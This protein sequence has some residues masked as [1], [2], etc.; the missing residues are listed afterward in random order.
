MKKHLIAIAVICALTLSACSNSAPETETDSTASLPQTTS[1]AP[2]TTTAETEAETENAE[3]PGDTELSENTED[4]EGADGIESDNIVPKEDYPDYLYG[5]GQDKVSADEIIRAE[6]YGICEKW[7][8]ATCEGFAYL[9]EPTGISF[10]NMENPDLLDSTNFTFTGAPKSTAEYKRYSVGDTICGLTLKEAL[11][12]FSHDMGINKTNPEAYFRGGYAGFEGSV[13]LSGYAVVLVDNE[14]GLGGEGDV[15]FMPDNES[16]ILPVMNYNCFSEERGVYSDIAERC[17]SAGGLVY[18]G[19]YG[20]IVLG[21]V[22]DDEKG[23]FT[24]IEKNVPVKVRV[25]G[26]DVFVSASV[27]WMARV[28]LTVTDFEVL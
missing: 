8:F 19:E 14:Y 16:Q 20:F 25:K 11:M 12:D 9:A 10:N 6:T 26:E 5:P 1:I 2:K 18:Q 7:D 24:G 15:I 21:N 13:E 3:E 23:W 22:G 4:P 27:D 17:F 28:S